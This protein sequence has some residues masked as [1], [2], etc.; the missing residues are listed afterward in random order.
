MTEEQ[1]MLQL[2]DDLVKRAEQR[3]A[4]LG[5]EGATDLGKTQLS[6]AIEIMQTAGSIPVFVNWLRYQAGRE[7]S[8]VF[9]TRAAGKDRLAAAVAHDLGWIQKQID[10]QLSGLSKAQQSAFATRASSRYL[11]YL[12][13]A[14]IGAKFLTLVTLDGGTAGEATGNG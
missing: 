5:V 3:V 14:L 1:L 8:A 2:Q 7:R 6:R 11:G 12:R 4:A 9:W 10:E 13:R